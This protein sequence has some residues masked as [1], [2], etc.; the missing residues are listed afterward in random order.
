MKLYVEDVC[1]ETKAVID[2][3]CEGLEGLAMAI[4]Q[5]VD[6][7]KLINLIKEGC[8]KEELIETIKK[9][10]SSEIVLPDD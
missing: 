6:G 4:K 1:K 9:M 3:L 10:Q 8:S 7:D 5:L 2:E